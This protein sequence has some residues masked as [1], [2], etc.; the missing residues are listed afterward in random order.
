M[1]YFELPEITEDIMTTSYS[2]LYAEVQ[3]GSFV[4]QE[5]VMKSKIEL[6]KMMGEGPVDV[7]MTNDNGRRIY[8]IVR[9]KNVLRKKYQ[10]LMSL[11]INLTQANVRIEEL[12]LLLRETVMRNSMALP[13]TD[14]DTEWAHDGNSDAGF[15]TRI[16][17]TLSLGK[18]KTTDPLGPQYAGDAI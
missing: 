4:F 17:T 13:E 18:Y 2:N 12:Q 7:H 1:K 15:I 8:Q 14:Q 16:F 5:G 10:E 3:R 11:R 6:E 9:N